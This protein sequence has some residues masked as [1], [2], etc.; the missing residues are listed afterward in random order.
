MVE[1]FCQNKVTNA[2]NNARMRKAEREQLERDVKL[3]R[4]EIASLR[5]A[6]ANTITAEALN[7]ELNEE[8]REH[9]ATGIRLPSDDKGR[10]VLVQEK[11]FRAMRGAEMLEAIRRGPVTFPAVPVETTTSGGESDEYRIVEEKK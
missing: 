3:L 1:K 6:T 2:Q 4:A 9:V 10:V 8:V 7:E 5:A 11:V